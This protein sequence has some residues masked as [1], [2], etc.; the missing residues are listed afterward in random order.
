MEYIGPES[1]PKFSKAGKWS[2]KKIEKYLVKE[3]KITAVTRSTIRR[4][5]KLLEQD[6]ARVAELVGKPID[7]EEI[8]NYLATIHENV[9]LLELKTLDNQ[10]LSTL[11]LISREE[12]ILYQHVQNGE[13][14]VRMLKEKSI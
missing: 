8:G 12:Q 13:Y 9:K 14:L 2:A 1:N 5:Q 6:L 11:A 7:V 3:K 10:I 4:N